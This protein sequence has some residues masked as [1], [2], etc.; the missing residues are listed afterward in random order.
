MLSFRQQ[1]GVWRVVGASAVAATHTGNTDETALA[2]VTLPGGAMGPNGALRIT[3]TWA[4]SNNANVKTLRYRLGGL[5]GTAFLAHAPTT[6]DIANFQR[7]IQNRNSQASQ[8]SFHATGAGSFT[9][10]GSGSAVV[11]GAIDT[12]LPQDLVISGQ[13]ASA[14]D[15]ITLHAW[16]VELLYKG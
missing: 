5:A 9:A 8:F 6:T 4:Y 15:S 10:L 11:T 13:L 16:L 1:S 3:S 7:V 14:G 12:S 2:T